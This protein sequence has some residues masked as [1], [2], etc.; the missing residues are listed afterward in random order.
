LFLFTTFRGGKINIKSML[1]W[2]FAFF[3]LFVIFLGQSDA[4]PKRAVNMET[5]FIRIDRYIDFIVAV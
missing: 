3:I 1:F 4:L 2:L 5:A